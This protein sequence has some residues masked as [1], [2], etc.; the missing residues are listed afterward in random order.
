M[1][2]KV[3]AEATMIDTLAMASRRI[4]QRKTSK[5]ADAFL[6]KWVNNYKTHS[7]ISDLKWYPLQLKLYWFAYLRLLTLSGLSQWAPSNQRQLT[8]TAKVQILI[9]FP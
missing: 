8:Q 7:H 2:S 1:T 9:L 3:A 4:K 6:T 5:T